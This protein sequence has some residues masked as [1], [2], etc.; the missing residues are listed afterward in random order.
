VPLRKNPLVLAALGVTWALVAVLLFVPWLAGTIGH[1]P[2]TLRGLLWAL[3][4]FPVVLLA[5]WVSKR[6]RRRR[7]SSVARAGEM[8]DHAL[9]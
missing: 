5:D 8:L 7:T 6:W 3:S 1:A 9:S 2:P 4:A